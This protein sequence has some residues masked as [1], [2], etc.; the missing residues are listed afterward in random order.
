MDVRLVLEKGRARVREIRLRREETIV[1]RQKGSDL[2]IPSSEVS[3]RHCILSTQR[4]YLTVEDLDSANGTF[5]NGQPIKG[6]KVVRPGDR[7]RIGPLTFVVEYQL[8]Q[9]AI[10]QLLAGDEVLEAVADD[11][12][13]VMVELVEDEA[14]AP[15]HIE[16]EGAPLPMSDDHDTARHEPGEEE[17]PEEVDP[18]AAL[19]LAEDGADILDMD[20]KAAPWHLPEQDELR[21]IL[22]ELEQFDKSSPEVKARKKSS[23]EIETDKN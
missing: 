2:R 4:G 11:N 23:P 13:E 17:A 21:D 14:P 6:K 9:A 15:A 1:G 19:P 8:T 5:L 7:V 12:D 3:R 16:D 22:S 20:N 18:N 10:D